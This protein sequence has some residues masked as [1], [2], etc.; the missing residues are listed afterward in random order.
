MQRLSE[1]ADTSRERLAKISIF[2][3]LQCLVA[4]KGLPLMA[5]EYAE[6]RHYWTDQRMIVDSL[7]KAVVGGMTTTTDSGIVTPISDAF[8]A[9]LR[10]SVIPMQLS[11]LRRV[12]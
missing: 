3:Y 12:E 9:A 2:R 8:L 5:T 10:S 11:N 7:R 6:A 1:I 4:S